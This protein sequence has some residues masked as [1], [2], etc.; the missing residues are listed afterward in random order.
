[1]KR[2][3][4]L[5]LME[6]MITMVIIGVLAAIAWPM[7]DEQRTKNR[8]T[9]G[10]RALL[11]NSNKLQA[12]Y[13]DKGSYTNCSIVALSK[14]GHYDITISKTDETYTLTARPNASGG[15][16]GDSDCTTLTLTHLGVR[17]S[18]GSANKKRC[19]AD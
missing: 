16:V 12:C 1:M 15:Q 17:G 19:W 3:Q 14:D 8:R 5:T 10:I 11:E 2:Q 9:D 4:G 6:V 13:T 18:T 7:F